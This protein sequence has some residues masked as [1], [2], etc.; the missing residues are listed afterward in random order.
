MNPKRFAKAFVVTTISVVLASPAGAPWAQNRPVTNF[1]Y[2]ANGNLTSTTDALGRVTS[3]TYDTLNRLTK[4]TQPKPVGTA[5]NPVTQFGVD[6]LDQL[7][8][9]TDARSLVTSYTVTGLGNLTQ[10]VSPDT[11]TTINTFDAAGNLK[12]ARTPA[13][14]P[15]PT[16]TTASTA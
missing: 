4:V 14:R 6:G 10:Q 15:P 11:G 9:V 12:P 5:P 8:S 16:P 1:Q 2:D 13:A 3:Q 7:T